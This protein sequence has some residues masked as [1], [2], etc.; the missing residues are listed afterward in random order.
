MS[1]ISQ[2]TVYRQSKTETKLLQ[3]T[4]F[5]N[6]TEKRDRRNAADQLWRERKTSGSLNGFRFFIAKLN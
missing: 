1:P 5:P 4:I 3:M 2:R 6:Q